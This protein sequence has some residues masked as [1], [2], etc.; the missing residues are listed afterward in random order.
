MQKFHTR[1]ELGRTFREEEY[2]DT[3]PITG[4]LASYGG[5]GFVADFSVT[6]LTGA[7]AQIQTRYDETLWLDR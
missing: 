4:K 2:F 6:N 3:A 1:F 7:D 5:G